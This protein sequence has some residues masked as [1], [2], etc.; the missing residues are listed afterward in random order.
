MSSEMGGEQSLRQLSRPQKAIK[1]PFFL[2]FS[3]PFHPPPLPKKSR[4][5]LLSTTTTTLHTNC[6]I[7]LLHLTESLQLHGLAFHSSII[8]FASST[9]LKGQQ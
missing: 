3:S 4:K 9:L 6:P 5:N 7:D 2:S 8:S 1:G